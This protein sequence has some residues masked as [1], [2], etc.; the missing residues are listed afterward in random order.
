M[1]QN[2]IILKADRVF[3]TI[4]FTETVI[5]NEKASAEGEFNYI[6]M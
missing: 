2:E 5:W 3:L 1:K 4:E 6:M